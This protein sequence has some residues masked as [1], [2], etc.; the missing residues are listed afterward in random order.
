MLNEIDLKIIARIQ[1]L[2]IV[3]LSIYPGYKEMLEQ[4]FK[5]IYLELKGESNE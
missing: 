1:A 2:E 4:E 5:K 3:L